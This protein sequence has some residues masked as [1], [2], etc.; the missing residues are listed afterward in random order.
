[1]W[2]EYDQKGLPYLRNLFGEMKP[3]R[4]F[5]RY[6]ENGDAYIRQSENNGL[7][8]YTGYRSGGPPS[9]KSQEFLRSTT[10]HQSC[11]SSPQN[12][13]KRYPEAAVSGQ[14]SGVIASVIPSSNGLTDRMSRTMSRAIASMIPRQDNQQ[15]RF[16]PRQSSQET[17]IPVVQISLARSATAVGNGMTRQDSQLGTSQRSRVARPSPAPSRNA[18]RSSDEARSHLFTSTSQ[19]RHQSPGFAVNTVPSN[20]QY[21]PIPSGMRQQEIQYQQAGKASKLSDSLLNSNTPQLSRSTTPVSQSRDSNRKASSGIRPADQSYALPMA[22][23]QTVT[24]S[25]PRSQMFQGN[26]A[27]QSIDPY[28][29]NMALARTN[30]P[31]LGH[32]G[33]SSPQ[34]CGATYQMNTPFQT[35]AFH[36]KP[37]D[38]YQQ[39]YAQAAPQPGTQKRSRE[40][41]NPDEVDL[42]NLSKRARGPLG[43]AQTPSAPAK[44]PPNSYIQAVIAQT[45]PLMMGNRAPPVLPGQRRGPLA[46]VADPKSR[47]ARSAYSSPYIPGSTIAQTTNIQQT[48]NNNTPVYSLYGQQYSSQMPTSTPSVRKPPVWSNPNMSHKKALDSER[49]QQNADESGSY[50]RPYVLDNVDIHCSEPPPPVISSQEEQ[51]ATTKEQSPSL[52]RP[53]TYYEHTGGTLT[54]RPPWETGV[55]ANMDFKTKSFID[56]HGA[57]FSTDKCGGYRYVKPTNRVQELAIIP[58]TYQTIAD[59]ELYLGFSPQSKIKTWE[60]Y[61]TQYRQLQSELMTQW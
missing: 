56:A 15:L 9:E 58:A 46:Y 23:K 22:S 34:T 48:S 21:S 6:Q 61:N 47:N 2:P 11:N 35:Q 60:N 8:R 13:Q 28:L 52:P 19:A 44:T 27:G 14:G 7:D 42:L 18:N 37:T 49:V 53:P 5:P 59:F 17:D 25:P 33:V 1:M 50:Q 55:C 26:H 24:P 43:Q 4:I 16:N 39:L 30:S 29:Q 54:S 45:G 51:P 41:T 40:A 36:Q 12:Q 20:R 31:F 10:D 32:R 38:N 57:D 3:T